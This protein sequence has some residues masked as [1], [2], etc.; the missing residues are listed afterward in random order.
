M[1]TYTPETW[2]DETGVGDGTEFTA[3]RMNNIEAGILDALHLND[4]ES[5]S[6]G[7][8]IAFDLASGLWVVTE[9][10]DPALLATAQ[11]TDEKD[12]P[13]GYAGLDGSGKLATSQIPAVALTTVQVAASQAAM[14]ALTTQAGDVVIRTDQ[15]KSYMH[16]GGTAGTMA[17]FTVLDTPLDAVTS[18]NGQTGTVVLNY[19]DVGA[20]AAHANLTQLA[21]LSLVADKLIYASGTG[22]LSLATLTAYMRTLLDDSDA[23]S[24]LATLTA[25]GLSLANVFTDTNVWDRTGDGAVLAF[26]RGGTTYGVLSV[27]LSGG[28]KILTLGSVEKFTLTASG[29][30]SILS[31]FGDVTLG[32]VGGALTL[33]GTPTTVPDATTA[34]GALNRQTGDARYPLKSAVPAATETGMKIIR[35]IVDTS[36][37][38]SI[39]KGSGFTITRNGVGDVTINFTAAFSDLP[40]VTATGYAAAA[41]S[42]LVD[43][44]ALTTSAVRLRRYRSSTE[45]NNDEKIHFIAIGPA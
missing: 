43:M 34:T 21:G 17:D 38:G 24:A 44:I 40:T 11:Q 39:V 35:G 13:G 29:A 25:P 32:S 37:S 23:A 18:V 19:A 4:G 42:P 14:L 7:D 15:H 5:P 9:L 6:D 33:V 30:M 22:V 20:Q 41:Q 26:K 2:V 28:V 1:A 45:I 36:G 3:D 10:A 27:S 12:Q 31:T 16:N 8:G